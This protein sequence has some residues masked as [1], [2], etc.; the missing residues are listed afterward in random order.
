MI[1]YIMWKS[2]IDVF[3][4]YSTKIEKMSSY[5]FCSFCSIITIPLDIIFSIF[6]LLG[7]IIYLI[8]K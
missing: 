2:F 7:I 6:E 5:A 4:I 8:T 3:N 1:T